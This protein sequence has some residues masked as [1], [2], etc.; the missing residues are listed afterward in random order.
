MDAISR[1]LEIIR[2]ALPSIELR[3]NEPMKNHTSFRIGGPVRA[4]FFPVHPDELVTLHGLINDNGIAPLIIGNG[5]NMLVEDKA[6][7]MVVINTTNISHIEHSENEAEICA[8]CGTQL[9]A[10]AKYACD[11][12][13]SGLEFAY[14]IPGTLGGAVTM[15]AGAYGGEMKDIIHSTSAFILGTGR[16]T[17]IGEEHRFSYRSSRFLG[18]DEIILSTSVRLKKGE[19]ESIRAKMDELME[20]RR[21]S[22]PLES[23]NAGSTFKRPEGGYAAAL[24]EQAG[25][26]GYTIGGAQV[27]EKHS[28]FIVNRADASFSDVMAVIEHVQESVLHQFGIELELEVMIIK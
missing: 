8:Y 11:L 28:G 16:V 27:S 9:S 1:I 6:L 12:S 25:L 10:L 7:D 20:R 23:Q 26:K 22:Q 17:V 21:Q 3:L 13:L 19:T 2:N 5:T 24:V 4:M 18:S 15:N 14:G